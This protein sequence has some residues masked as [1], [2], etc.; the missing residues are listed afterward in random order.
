MSL[1]ADLKVKYGL[2]PD[3]LTRILSWRKEGLSWATI[4]SRIAW[5]APTLFRHYQW[6]AKAAGYT[7]EAG[8][9]DLD[10]AWPDSAGQPRGPVLCESYP[11]CPCGDGTHRHS[12]DG[13][14]RK[15]EDS[16]CWRTPNVSA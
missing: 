8:C 7:T 12:A 14:G 2:G 10:P 1:N 3:T 11:R 16:Q 9:P 5:H 6:A 4:A 13:D 15:V